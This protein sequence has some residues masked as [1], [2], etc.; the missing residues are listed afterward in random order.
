MFYF[1][2]WFVKI[3][4]TSQYKLRLHR[5]FQLSTLE[6]KT[7]PVICHCQDILQKMEMGGDPRGNEDFQ[8]M[9]SESVSNT[10]AKAIHLKQE[11][12]TI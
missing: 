3:L 4:F 5:Y 12:Y 6:C 1:F 9:K 11:S 7:G 2:Y 8:D 10:V